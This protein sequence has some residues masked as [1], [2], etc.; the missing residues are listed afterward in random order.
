[1]LMPHPEEPAMTYSPDTAY[2]IARMRADDAM[3][4]AARERRANEMLRASPNFIP[5]SR[6]R[7]AAYWSVIV[8]P[9]VAV[10]FLSYFGHAIAQIAG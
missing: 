1:M 6:L 3:A 8:G 5:T 9:I 7:D 10:G 2:E 4:E